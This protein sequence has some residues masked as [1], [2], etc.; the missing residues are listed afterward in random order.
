MITAVE[1]SVLLDVLAGTPEAS[2]RAAERLALCAQ[3]GRLVV[4]EMVVAEV[5]PEVGPE[6]M[7]DFL[8]D[9][10]LEFVASSAASA[11]LAG[12]MDADYLRRGGKRGRVVPDFLIGAHALTHADRLLTRDAGFERDCFGDLSTL[13]P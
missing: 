3:E 5:A 13:A 10:H 9:W 1:S 4:C 8:R 12:R 7:E 11:V 6:R 2:L